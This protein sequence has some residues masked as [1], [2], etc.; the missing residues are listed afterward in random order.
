[1]PS[2]PL[3]IEP[4]TPHRRPHRSSHPYSRQFVP[5]SLVPVADML[6]HGSVGG[7]NVRMS[8]DGERGAFRMTARRHV[9]AGELLVNRYREPSP[10]SFYLA[11]WDF[12]TQP[13]EASVSVPVGP[14][15]DGCGAAGDCPAGRPCRLPDDAYQC[16]GSRNVAGAK[17]LDGLINL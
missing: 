2:A 7:L 15:A 4:L 8:M 11:L 9:R 3:P 1:M 17:I 13:P 14:W 10:N 5:A 6:D 16:Q 12:T